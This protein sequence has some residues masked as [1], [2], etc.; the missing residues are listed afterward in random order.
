MQNGKTCA[1]DIG[2]LSDG[3]W[4]AR[5]E[6]IG[7]E[8]G[9]FQWLGDAHAGVFVDAGRTLLVTFETVD[10]IRRNQPGQ[11][12]LGY[13]VAK[14]RQWSHLCLIARRATWYR[15]KAVYAFFDRLVDD[16]FFEEFDKVVFYGAG[17]AGYAAAAFSVTAPG[18]T[19]ILAAPQATL[20]PEVT[21]W[22]PRFLE[23]R[24][25]SF[26]DRYGY[27]PDMT[28]GAGPVFVI[29]DPEQ[30]LDAMHAA[31]FKRSH[32][33]LLPCRNLGRDIGGALEAMRILPSVLTTACTGSFD[34][35][36]FRIFYRARR[37]YRPYLRGLLAR[38][39]ADGRTWLAALL[40]RNVADRLSGAEKFEA[41]LALL[42][43]QLES[44]GQSLPSARS[45][46]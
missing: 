32:V 19:V 31:L 34:R 6:K 17:M 14:G 5:I 3:S 24:R 41:R 40:C 38:L 18:A 29:Y 7:Q 37:N 1:T 9:Y 46:Q 25:T 26:N 35:H 16:G 30:N 39:E 20:D 33:T 43:S 4:F 10:G 11:L 2:E 23:L 22:D 28:E 8:Q 27:A 15:D 12:P 45:R 21:G 36:L 44:S 42:E 13:Q